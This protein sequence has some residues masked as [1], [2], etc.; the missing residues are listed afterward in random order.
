[1]T[2]K[3]FFFNFFFLF[4]GETESGSTGIRITSCGK[5][6]PGE[7]GGVCVLR[8]AFTKTEGNNGCLSPEY[9]RN[10][11]ASQRNHNIGR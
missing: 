10:A 4:V 11:H 7:E 9:L 3:F 8:L 5:R 2:L 6:L 1:M